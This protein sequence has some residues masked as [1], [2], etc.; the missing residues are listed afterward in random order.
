MEPEKY[1]SIT[2]RNFI[3]ATG[4]TLAAGSG[5]LAAQSG[6]RLRLAMVGTGMRGTLTWGIPVVKGYGDILEF[7]GLC[8]INSKRV[9]V[10]QAMI[11]TNAPVF[12]DFDQMVKQTKPD[13]VMVT[14]TDRK[15]V[16]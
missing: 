7:V 14:T 4:A 2:R 9:K 8:D 11:G 12:T 6:K 5:R 10:A 1:V 3:A 13:V 16:V 15:S